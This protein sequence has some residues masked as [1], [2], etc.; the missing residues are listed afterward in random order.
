M[1]LFLSHTQDGTKIYILVMQVTMHF[2]PLGT[3][4]SWNFKPAFPTK[5]YSYNVVNHNMDRAYNGCQRAI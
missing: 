5:W 2:Q 4:Y 3:V 1:K